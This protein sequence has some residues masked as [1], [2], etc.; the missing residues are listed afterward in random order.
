MEGKKKT[1]ITNSGEK[2]GRKLGIM[3]MENV[4]K[5]IMIMTLRF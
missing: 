2:N 3:I 1:R 4:G 5:K